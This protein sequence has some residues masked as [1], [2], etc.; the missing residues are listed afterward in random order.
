MEKIN[1]GRTTGAKDFD[2]KSKT[3]K[4]TRISRKPD[5]KWIAGG[6]SPNPNGRP[7]GSKNKNTAKLENIL[8]ESGECIVNKITDMALNGNTACLKRHYHGYI[9]SLL[10]Q[11]STCQICRN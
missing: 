6:V 2:K 8:Q 10:L 4:K 1:K 3:R 9:Q 5:G 11:K 7:I